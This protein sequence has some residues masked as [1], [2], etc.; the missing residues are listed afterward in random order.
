MTVQPIYKLHA[1]TK[2]DK[3]ALRSLRLRFI[4]ITANNALGEQF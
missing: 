1:L 2:Y 3:A 4:N